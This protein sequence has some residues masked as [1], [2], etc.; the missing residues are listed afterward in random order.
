MPEANSNTDSSMN[1]AKPWYRSTTV[2]LNL[3]ALVSLAIPAVSEWVKNNPVEPVAVL[4]AI[5]VLVR[6]ATQGKVTLFSSDDGT[7]GS[8]SADM[9]VGGNNSTGGGSG[10]ASGEDNAQRT[11]SLS[12]PIVATCA[13]AFLLPSCNPATWSAIG[14]HFD[15]KAVLTHTDES[16][17]SAS[18]II[19]PKRVVAQKSTSRVAPVLKDWPPIERHP[20][21]LVLP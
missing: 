5:N 2:L 17:N 16:G 7:S 18:V 13:V 1:P 10:A 15:A 6:F 3:L 12:W 8:G 21:R 20:K 11:W 4:G 19:R 14:Q 9:G